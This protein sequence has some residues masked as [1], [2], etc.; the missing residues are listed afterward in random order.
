MARI[1]FVDDESGF[2]NAAVR[3]F[4]K[5]DHEIVTAESGSLAL[6]LLAKEKF[7]LVVLDYMMP[8]MDGIE[9]L[10]EI[11]K[12]DFALPVIMCTAHGSVHLAVEFMK[13]RNAVYFLEKP[14]D[15]RI[16]AFKVE[17]ALKTAEKDSRMLAIEVANAAVR[18]NLRTLKTLAGGI[19][20]EINNALTVVRGNIELIKI[21]IAENSKTD[22]HFDSVKASIQRMSH[23]TN[24]LLAY[25]QEGKYQSKIVPLCAFLND[26]FPLIIKG[27][28]PA[29]QVNL[30]LTDSDL[31]VEADL[32]QMHMVISSVIANAVDA[33][34]GPGTIKI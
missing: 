1:L 24:Q 16:L 5:S 17:E 31:K 6:E 30:D 21:E 23:L 12:I 14:L 28:D 20:H 2:L 7:D 11:R 26:A 4:R 25:A 34:E 10:D 9:T 32:M 19:S 8:G 22:K 27:V 29:T 13:S 33:I 15:F 18:E 3:H